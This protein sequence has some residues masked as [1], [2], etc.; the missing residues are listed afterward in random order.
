M[1]RAEGGQEEADGRSQEAGFSASVA[2]EEPRAGQYMSAATRRYDDHTSRLMS[3]SP[4]L[5]V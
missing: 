1:Q 3:L 4:C 2:A 5:C